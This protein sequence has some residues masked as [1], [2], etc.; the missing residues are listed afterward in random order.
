MY[1]TSTI[2]LTVWPLSFFQSYVFLQTQT[3]WCVISENLCCINI[4]K[5]PS[6]YQLFPGSLCWDL[7]PY[8]EACTV[9]FLNHKILG[10]KHCHKDFTEVAL[11]LCDVYVYALP[12]SN[13]FEEIQNPCL[14]PLHTMS[15]F[16]LVLIKMWSINMLNKISCLTW[17]RIWSVGVYII[18]PNK[19]VTLQLSTAQY[20]LWKGLSRTAYI[21]LWY[22]HC[23]QHYRFRYIE[24]I[25]K[26][27]SCLPA[28]LHTCMVFPTLN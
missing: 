12:T 17:G 27:Q 1:S 21:I 3:I 28:P 9:A 16:Y 11:V 8:P 19:G 6:A 23:C 4:Y 22:G 5:V 26:V 7:F 2:W 18:M 20:S 15:L 14:E 13:S 24:L 25:R 10:L